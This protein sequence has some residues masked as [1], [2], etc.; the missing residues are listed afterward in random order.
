MVALQISTETR[1]SNHQPGNAS[2]DPTFESVGLWSLTMRKRRTLITS[3]LEWWLTA[4]PVAPPILPVVPERG[5]TQLR[6]PRRIALIDTREQNPFSFAR[7]KGWFSGI[8][9]KTLKTGQKS[10][11]DASQRD[12][13][14]FKISAQIRTLYLLNLIRSNSTRAKAA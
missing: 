4:A 9:R 12:V 10:D 14:E 13:L 1:P 8:E 11:M 3:P 5:G 6:T 7:F 2:V